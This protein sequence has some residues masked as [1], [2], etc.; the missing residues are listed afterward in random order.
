MTLTGRKILVTGG[1][2]FIGARLVRALAVENHV[3]VF[4]N[5]STGSLSGIQDLISG[6]AVDFIEGDVAR[7]HDFAALC[8]RA[9]TVF[10]LAVLNLREC[11]TDAAK[12]V[13]VNVQGTQNACTGAHRAGVDKFIYVSSSDIYGD[14]ATYPTPE[15]CLPRP[16]TIYGATKLAA[17]HIVSALRDSCGFPAIIVRPFNTYGPGEHITGSSGEV[18]PRFILYALAGSP[19]PIYGTGKQT[20]SFT[21]IDDTVRGIIAAASCGSPQT[22]PINIASA[23][24]IPIRMAAEMIYE[25]LGISKHDFNFL[26]ARPGDAERQC[27]DVSLAGRI[28]GFRAETS[29]AEGLPA[30]I[31]WVRAAATPLEKAPLLWP[32]SAAGRTNS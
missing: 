25:L 14:V 6:G 3:T 1:A 4:D 18:L 5:L 16:T 8:K 22:S 7:Y 24:E 19:L 13:E 23:E 28:L 32:G 29:L 21:F 31:S 9:D 20:R 12:A 15:C 10:H 2:G 26:P 30:L 17:E 27:A 11:M